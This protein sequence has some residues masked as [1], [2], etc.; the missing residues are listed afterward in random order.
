MPDASAA[1]EQPDMLHENNQDQQAAQ[2]DSSGRDDSAALDATEP[3]VPEAADL[4]AFLSGKL[5]KSKPGFA[6]SCARLTVS[7]LWL[8]LVNSLHC[9]A[10]TECF[11]HVSAAGL[12]SKYGL[13]SRSAAQVIEDALNADQIG[14]VHK[15]PLQAYSTHALDSADQHAAQPPVV[16]STQLVDPAASQ[17]MVAQGELALVTYAVAHRLR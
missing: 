10:I 12:R 13:N 4:S 16:P 9:P 3:G 15:A 1:L 14:I 11:R 17:A 5:L 6:A 7:T 8:Y 2:L